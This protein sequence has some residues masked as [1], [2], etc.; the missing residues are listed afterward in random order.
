MPIYEYRCTECGHEQEVILPFSEAT[1]EQRCSSCGKPT[2]RRISLPSPPVIPVTG[3]DK[4]FSALN[5]EGGYNLPTNSADRPRIE[6][7]LAKGLDQR[8]PV[9]GRG[10]GHN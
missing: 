5:K 10:F 3:R 6:A 9:I 2:N 4:V 8:S 7:A 1:A